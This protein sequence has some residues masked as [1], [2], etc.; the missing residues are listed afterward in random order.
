MDNPGV[1]EGS[2]HVPDQSAFFSQNVDPRK[3]PG[4]VVV[5]C[6]PRAASDLEG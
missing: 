1:S 5:N 6:G 4:P 3:H 2:L